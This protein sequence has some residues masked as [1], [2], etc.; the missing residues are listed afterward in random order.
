MTE[1]KILEFDRKDDFEKYARDSLETLTGILAELHI[2]FFFSACVSG[3]RDEDGT[4]TPKYVRTVRTPASFNGRIPAE[5]D[6]IS[7]HVMVTLG[8]RVSSAVSEDIGTVNAE[9]ADDD[10]ELIIG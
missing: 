3:M 2:P 8:A 4:Y 5:S 9:D 6:E 7:K 1:K 10:V